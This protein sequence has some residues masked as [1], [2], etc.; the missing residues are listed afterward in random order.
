MHHIVM[1][2]MAKSRALTQGR[3][4]ANYLTARMGA[5]GKD[6]S[7]GARALHLFE[8]TSSF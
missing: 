3:G 1:I 6:D 2:F 7:D 5:M 8:L 4:R